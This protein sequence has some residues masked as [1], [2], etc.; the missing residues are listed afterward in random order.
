MIIKAGHYVRG[1]N[2]IIEASRKISKINMDFGIVRLE[3]EH[4]YSGNEALEEMYILLNGELEFHFRGKKYSASRTSLLEQKPYAFHICSTQ[5]VELHA[6][7]DNCELALF[8]AEN[9]AN[10]PS[11]FIKPEEIE[12]VHVQAAKAEAYTG[13]TIRTAIDFNTAP[14]S[15][16]CCGEVIGSPGQW[17]S[18]PPHYHPQPEIYHYRFIPENG[19]GYSEEGD[20]VNK[21]MNGDTAALPPMVSHPQVAAPGYEMYYLWAIPHLENDPFIDTSR[22]YVEEHEW[23]AG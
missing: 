9:A 18:Y 21:V 3:K 22:I 10:F 23:V 11:K 13:R 15:K 2:S 14:F 20:R 5:T 1:Y 16:F 8:R 12:E 6:L 17:S 4:S 7:S 19:F